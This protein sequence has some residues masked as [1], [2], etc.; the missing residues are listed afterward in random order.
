MREIRAKKMSEN[1]EKNGKKS[2]KSKKSFKERCCLLWSSIARLVGYGINKTFYLWEYKGLDLRKEI[3]I[4]S[5]FPTHIIAFLD[6]QTLVKNCLEVNKSPYWNWWFVKATV[7]A[8]NIASKYFSDNLVI[9]LPWLLWNCLVIFL[10]MM[11]AEQ[12][13]FFCQ[14]YSKWLILIQVQPKFSSVLTC[15]QFWCSYEGILVRCF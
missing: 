4:P 8:K 2:N 1:K 9:C 5:V 10:P 11:C 6:K 15:L 13:L 12:R 3:W 14:E 7:D